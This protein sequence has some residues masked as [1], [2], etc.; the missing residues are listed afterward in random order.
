MALHHLCLQYDKVH[1]T[2][3]VFSKTSVFKGN[4][5]SRII[6][7]DTGMDIARYDYLA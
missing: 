4:F 6:G 2:L 5:F 3:L 1:V 7:A